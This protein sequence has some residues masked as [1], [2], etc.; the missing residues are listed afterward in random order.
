MNKTRTARPT[1]RAYGD[2]VVA[3]ASVGVLLAMLVPIPPLLLDLLLALNITFALLIF[4]ISLYI[5]RPL[6]L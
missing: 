4:V 1:S 2:V 3:L 6:D 5:L